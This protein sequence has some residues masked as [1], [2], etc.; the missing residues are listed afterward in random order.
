MSGF[1]SLWKR[2]L[3]VKSCNR[4]SE[5]EREKE[6]EAAGWKITFCRRELKKN[7]GE[8]FSFCVRS[9]SSVWCPDLH[10][11]RWRRHRGLGR[12]FRSPKTSWEIYARKS[13]NNVSPRA[14]MLQICD[15]N[16]AWKAHFVISEFP[17]WT[18]SLWA[19]TQKTC[20][21]LCPVHSLLVNSSK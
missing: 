12:G 4:V 8:Q 10:S 18:F 19:M 15:F 17:V 20:C 1:W 7:N 11:S 5:R 16:P 13:M 3:S 2:V 6:R 14:M 21:Y 9:C